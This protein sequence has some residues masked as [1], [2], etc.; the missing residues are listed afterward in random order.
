MLV[1][2]QQRSSMRDERCVV[3]PQVPKAVLGEIA[4][5]GSLAIVKSGAQIHESNP[6][7][8]HTPA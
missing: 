2:R 5:R 4:K 6:V 3:R 8:Q 1:K 7:R